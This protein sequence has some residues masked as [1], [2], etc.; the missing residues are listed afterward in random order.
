MKKD[1][2]EIWFP[3]MKYGI[4]WGFPITWQGWIV[5]L[6]Y[7]SLLLLGGLLIGNSPFLIIPFVIYVF[8]LSGILFYI[9]W[10]KGEK[11]DHHDF[12]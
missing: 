6:S 11:S 1:N 7:V 10:K 9:C 8:I 3:A 12:R 5:L 2:K 4:G